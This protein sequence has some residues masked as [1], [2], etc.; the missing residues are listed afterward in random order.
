MKETKE[1]SSE[2]RQQKQYVR[3]TEYPVNRLIL[4]LG[5]PTT[6]TMLITNIYNMADTYFVGQL[7][8]SASGATGIVFALMAIL[9]AIGFM[10]GQG[11]G[12]NI[13]RRL[14][15][16]DEEYASVFASTSFFMSLGV[17]ILL[18]SLGLI[19]LEPFMR[20]LGSTTTI[21]PYAKQYGGFILIA[22][23]ALITSCVMNNIL[24]FEGKAT[25]AMIGLTAGG[26]L[27][28]IMDPILMF[29]FDLGVAGAG[30]ST[31][32][33]QYISAGILLSMF[34][35]GRTQSKISIKHCTKKLED[36]GNVLMTG[37]PSLVRQG[38][39]SV[40]TLILN[41]TA[42]AYGDSAI[43]AMSIVSRFCMFLFCVSIGIGQGFQPVAGFNYGAGKYSR[44]KKG[45]K[46]TYLFSTCMLTVFA[47]AGFVA[48]NYVMRIFCDDAEVIVYGTPA[49][50]AQCA[51]LLT[52]PI[53]V[54]GNMLFQS[55]GKSVTATILS[56]MRSG[57]CFIPLIL[58]MPRLFGLA[59]VQ[60]AQ[61]LADVISGLI[62]IPF[63][64]RFFRSLPKED[65]IG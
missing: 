42:A 7:G 50:K 51:A 35:R 24:R 20:L 36:I 40:S 38:L 4:S 53:A 28:I 5:I 8:P 52:V 48:S 30:L 22:A 57:A 60:Y 11:A 32:L 62:T 64:V 61:P 31:A 9:Q 56:A 29:G 16:K 39:T 41:Q 23:P 43:A 10:F 63:L 18:M 21:L 15:A 47:I 17:S 12:S 6:I 26:I 46:F 13:S 34:L 25:F 3:M 55:I 59:G 44:L 14:G 1:L 2:E 65:K 27:N 33:S 49:L 54:C 37:M 58:I 45:F 19:F